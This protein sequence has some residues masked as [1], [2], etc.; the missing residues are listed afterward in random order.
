MS[1]N[2]PGEI[3]E[4]S[5]QKVGSSQSVSPVEL[6][7]DVAQPCFSAGKSMARK[8]DSVNAINL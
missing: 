1:K 3:L 6:G 7:M 8:C 4:V 2:L 5:T